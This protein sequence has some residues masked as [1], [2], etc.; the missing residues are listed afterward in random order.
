METTIGTFSKD[1][2]MDPSSMINDGW[3]LVTT[4]G[5]K[6]LHGGLA[7]EGFDS[8]DFWDFFFK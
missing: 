2:M 4:A 6:S 3:M 1:V 5:T 8:I 7:V